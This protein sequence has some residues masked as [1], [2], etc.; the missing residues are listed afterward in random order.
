MDDFT[1]GSWPSDCSLCCAYLGD[2]PAISADSA[3]VDTASPGPDQPDLYRRRGD[4][5]WT[6][7]RAY[8]E[9]AFERVGA[10]PAQF[11]HALE[12]FDQATAAQA[13]RLWHA[14]G[15]D[16]EGPKLTRAL[17]SAAEPVRRGFAAFSAILRQRA[18]PPNAPAPA[19]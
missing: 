2:P 5:V 8:A 11:V 4:G 3:L 9:R 1:S 16:L 10:E 12:P 7:P 15:R 17:E 19:R 13:A 6:S 18:A 14:A